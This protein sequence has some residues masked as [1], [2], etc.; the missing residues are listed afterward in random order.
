[1]DNIMATVKPLV[2][3]ALAACCVTFLIGCNP[4]PPAAEQ[5]KQ[6]KDAAQP[7]QPGAAQPPRQ[8]AAQPAA[9]PAKPPAPEKPQDDPILSSSTPGGRGNGTPGKPV[10]A[11]IAQLH[12]DDVNARFDA[13]AALG[14]IPF[15]QKP[16]EAATQAL[17]KLLKDADQNTRF[18]AALSLA[19]HGPFGVPA[20]LEALTDKD[21][22]VR[23]NAASC[24][25]PMPQINAAWPDTAE[26][27]MS[28]LGEVLMN[29]KDKEVR[30]TAARTLG[31]F[32]V[33]SI[34]MFLKAVKTGDKDARRLA[35]RALGRVPKVIYGPDPPRILLTTIPALIPLLKDEDA[36]MRTDVCK[37]LGAMGDQAGEAIPA[38]LLASKVQDS[39]GVAAVDAL[40]LI[41]KA[42]ASAAP[43]LLPFLRDPDPSVRLK[44]AEALCASEEGD[45]ECLPALVELVGR[46]DSKIRQGAALVLFQYGS[47]AK[48]AVPALIEAVRND[49]DAKTRIAA[50]NAL[51]AVGPDAK[52]ALPGLKAILDDREVGPAAQ[53]A[54]KKIDQ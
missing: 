22:G 42:P 3:L 13:I 6:G 38:L 11:W 9:D 34:P 16:P 41:H 45:K 26:A 52:A 53:A 36:G 39:T 29:D 20:F 51:G 27:A 10:S 25:G 46:R 32:G 37:T 2:R 47:A 49:P 19:K 17:G 15:G 5:P 50:I 23:K 28:A 33:P 4:D 7:A 48:E 8:D 35:V 14:N 1:L 18:A 30:E 40:A 24:M 43:A 31:A 54:L 44:A 21:A 12:A